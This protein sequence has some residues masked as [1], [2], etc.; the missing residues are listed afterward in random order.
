MTLQFVAQGARLVVRAERPA[1]VSTIKI[2]QSA[3]GALAG[4]PPSGS[5]ARRGAVRINKRTA[6]GTVTALAL[7]PAALLA[8]CYLAEGGMFFADD[9]SLSINE[10]LEAGDTMEI[11]HAAPD[12]V[13]DPGAGSLP[14]AAI[15]LRDVSIDLAETIIGP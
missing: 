2:A 7:I 9:I 3:R 4:K 6:A 12:P 5:T 10:D 14:D 11:E 15:A 1:R 13:E 8:G